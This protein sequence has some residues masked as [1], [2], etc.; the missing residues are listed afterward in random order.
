[1]T[2]NQSNQS[3]YCWPVA[4]QWAFGGVGRSAT[5]RVLSGRHDRIRTGDLYH[6]KVQILP[7]FWAIYPNKPNLAHFTKQSL[8]VFAGQLLATRALLASE[9]LRASDRWAL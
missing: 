6:V 4:G 5:A 9:V 1:M 8:S 3:N 7:V 2:Q